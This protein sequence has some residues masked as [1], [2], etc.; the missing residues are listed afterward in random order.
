VDAESRE[1]FFDLLAELNAAGMTVLLVEHDIGVVTTYA[2]TVAC[3]NR[4]VY[5]H[6]DPVAFSESDALQRAYGAN[7]QV[8]THD[9]GHGSGGDHRHGSGGDHRH[10]VGSAGTSEH[11]RS[12][13][14]D[15]DGAGDT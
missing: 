15:P 2:T 7:Q 14:T 9:H 12:D 4:Q 1:A 10:G 3:V 11:R 6:G 8:L 13:D 5:F